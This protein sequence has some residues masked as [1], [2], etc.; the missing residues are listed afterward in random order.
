MNLSNTR[1]S[2]TSGNSDTPGVLA[3]DLN[4]LR[5]ILLEVVDQ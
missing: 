5:L 3:I 1:T 4:D 2:R